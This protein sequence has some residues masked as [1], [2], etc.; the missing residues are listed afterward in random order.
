MN[1]SAA[2]RDRDPMRPPGRSQLFRDVP[3]VNLNRFFGDTQPLSDVAIP[4]SRRDE[5][6][7]LKFAIGERLI[8]DMLG[9]TGRDLRQYP[10]R[11]HRQ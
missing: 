9:E 8:G 3:D 10:G 5:A 4:V 7:N 6:Q 11:P 2:D 1:E